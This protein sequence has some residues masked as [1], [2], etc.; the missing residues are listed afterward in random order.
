MLFVKAH[1]VLSDHI[2]IICM[3]KIAAVSVRESIQGFFFFHLRFCVRLQ[4]WHANASEF[5]IYS[6]VLNACFAFDSARP[7]CAYANVQCNLGLLSNKVSFTSRERERWCSRE[8]AVN[9]FPLRK[10]ASHCKYFIR[11]GSGGDFPSHTFEKRFDK[12][13]KDDYFL[14]TRMVSLI[15]PPRQETLERKYVNRFLY[16]RI[17]MRACSIFLSY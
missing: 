8:T 15:S 2:L 5:W 6:T 9:V 3:C 11:G 12:Y 7:S 17:F 13:S 14:F 1:L 4:S 16:A 10:W